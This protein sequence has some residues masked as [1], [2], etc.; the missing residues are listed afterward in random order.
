[1]EEIRE[2]LTVIAKS[3]QVPTSVAEAVRK[4]VEDQKSSTIDGQNWLR[5]PTALTLTISH[6]KRKY[7]EIKPLRERSWVFE[8]YLS[9]VD[10]AYMKDLKE[11]HDKPNENFDME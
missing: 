9:S 3:A 1:M 7:E 2:I 11:I 4:A 5:S 8:M 6:K 10:E